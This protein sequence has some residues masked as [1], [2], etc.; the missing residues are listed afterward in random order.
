[1]SIT[2]DPGTLRRRLEYERLAETPDGQGGQSTVWQK[3]FDV[4]AAIRPTGAAIADQ[5]GNRQA[6]TS[7]DIV[8]RQRPDIVAG[9]RFRSGDR[10][11]EILAVFDPDETGR[12]LQCRCRELR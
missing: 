5:A 8:L 4:W 12:Y 11:F 9:M 6:V 10:L 1:M 3:Q 2:F 7:H